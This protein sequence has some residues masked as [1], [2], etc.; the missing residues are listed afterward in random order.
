MTI[1]YCIKCRKGVYKVNRNGIGYELVCDLCGYTEY[2]FT[3]KVL[4]ERKQIKTNQPSKN[5]V[6]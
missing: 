4:L 2:R 5:I 3:P 6:R 1:Q